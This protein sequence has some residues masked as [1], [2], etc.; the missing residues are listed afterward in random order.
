LRSVDLARE[1][2]L[3]PIDGGKRTFSL[4]DTAMDEAL[5]N[6]E[7]L[8]LAASVPYAE[9]LAGPHASVVRVSPIC[10]SR[11]TVDIDVDDD[12]RVSRF[13]QEVRACAL[14]QAAAALLG[15]GVVGRNAG[16]LATA[17]TALAG[18]L[19]GTSDTPGDWPGLAVLGPARPHKARHASILLAF[20]AA[21][22]A[23]AA[24]GQRQ[25]A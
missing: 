15:N 14:G 1:Q 13:G 18:F 12:G 7:I 9:R 4:L 8:R 5:Y 2:W 17:H 20:D 24:A 6:T 10:G 11:V 21:A 22:A 3:D 19:R 25:P 16:E 23:A